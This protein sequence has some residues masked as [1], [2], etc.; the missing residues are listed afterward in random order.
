[1]EK[2]PQDYVANPLNA[3]IL[4]KTLSHDISSIQSSL[5]ETF[6]SFNNSIENIKLPNEDFEGAVEGFVRL[7]KV[8][9]LKSEDLADGFVD[10]VKIRDELSGLNLFI[11][12]NEITK[13]DRKIASEYFE[14][15]SERSSEEFKLDIL[16]K[17][18]ENYLE[19]EKYSK[20]VEVLEEISEIKGNF[21]KKVLILN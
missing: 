21:F 1:M 8:Y 7:Q 2:N 13:I 16:D 9:E 19:M 5:Y 15:A 20:A 14:I 18:V 4:I 11:L 10:D 3:F 6:Q 12:A 17:M